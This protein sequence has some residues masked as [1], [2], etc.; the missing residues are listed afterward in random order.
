MLRKQGPPLRNYVLPIMALL[1]TV[2][3]I[4]W[5]LES[6]ARS[7]SWTEAE[8]ETLQSLWIGSLAAL[9]PDPSNAVADDPRAAKF[10]QQL[11]FDRRLSVNAAIS[12]STCHQPER[13]FTDGL[14]KGLA[15]GE[16][17]RNTPSIV[18]AAYSPWLYWDGR[19]DSLWSQAISP[20]E[21]VNEHGGSRMQYVHL[22][23]T[24]PGY[25]KTYEEIFGLLPDL[26]DRDRF[27]ENAT[28]ITNTQWNN[29]EWN[30]AWRKMTEQDRHVSNKIF[31]NIGKSIAAYERLLMPGPSRFDAYVEAVMSGNEASQ[32]QLFND[33]EIMGLRLFIG[34]ANCTQCHNGPL[35]TN[36]EFHNTGVTSFPGEVPDKGRVQGVRNIQLDP[37]NCLG[38]YA[39]SNANDCS[40]LRFART[41]PELIGAMRTPSLRNLE[42]TSPFMHKGQMATLAQVLDHYNRAP[43]AMIG[44]NETEPL[45]LSRRELKQLESFLESLAAAIATPP[46]WLEAPAVV[47]GMK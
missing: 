36:N 42:G 1:V 28:P 37:F 5:W 17:K 13:R 21:D 3:I 6:S 18:G 47:E 34:E 30:H 16:S 44:H 46:E 9:S 39:D 22:I 11:F 38:P 26:S 27:P 25:K 43:L 41:G 12:C 24:D 2:V 35:L 19:R 15:I 4:A 8:I 20:L 32:Q 31:S 14:P 29:V 7:N 10:G 40:E 33:D 23:V 45:N